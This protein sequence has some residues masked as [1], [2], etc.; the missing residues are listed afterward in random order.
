VNEMASELHAFS[1]EVISHHV[2]SCSSQSLGYLCFFHIS[3]RCKDT[4]ALSNIPLPLYSSSLPLRPCDGN[5]VDSQYR[6]RTEK[7]ITI[8]TWEFSDLRDFGVDHISDNRPFEMYILSTEKRAG[9]FRRSKNRACSATARLRSSPGDSRAWPPEASGARVSAPSPAR[10]LESAPVSP[11]PLTAET[12][13][14]SSPPSQSPTSALPAV[15]HRLYFAG[16]P[17]KRFTLL[18]S[19]YRDGDFHGRRD[20]HANTLTLLADRRVRC[21]ARFEKLMKW[22]ISRVGLRPESGAFTRAARRWDEASEVELVRDNLPGKWS[23]KRTMPPSRQ[24]R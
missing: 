19:A 2:K 22:S 5:P 18:W 16:F 8:L 3:K 13:F 10:S 17:G 6:L 21:R 23:A 4:F 12:G 9:G 20:G 14:S 24:P 15:A 1:R 7:H 11:R